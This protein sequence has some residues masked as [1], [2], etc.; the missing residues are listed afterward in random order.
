MS[1]RV[2]TNIDSGSVIR[3]LPNDFTRKARPKSCVV[4][5]VQSKFRHVETLLGSKMKSAFINLRNVNNRLP[6]DSNGFC[7]S[8]KYVAVPFSSCAGLVAIFEVNSLR[9]NFKIS[10]LVNASS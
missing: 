9:K 10:Y 2:A 4:G 5:I 1:I 3:N 6:A 7:V 8:K